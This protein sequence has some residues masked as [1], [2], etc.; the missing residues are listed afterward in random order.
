MLELAWTWFK[1]QPGNTDLRLLQGI[2]LG[3]TSALKF[4]EPSAVFSESLFF[5]CKGDAG[6][7]HP[8]LGGPNKLLCVKVL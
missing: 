7:S 4:T 3:V 8:A 2:L 5:N 1:I 6:H